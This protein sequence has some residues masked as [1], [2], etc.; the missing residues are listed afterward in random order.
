MNAVPAAASTHAAAGDRD[1]HQDNGQREQ[2]QYERGRD[3]GNLA[4][5]PAPSGNAEEQ[6]SK[7]GE[8]YDSD[9]ESE[10][11]NPE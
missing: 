5:G 3:D 7:R 6:G 10:E 4:N 8:K 11:R 9:R 2:Q 1:Q